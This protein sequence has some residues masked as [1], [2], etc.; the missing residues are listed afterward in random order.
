MAE[1]EE[2]VEAEMTAE[3]EPLAEAEVAD[4]E[5]QPGDDVT[6]AEQQAD[7]EEQPAN[8]QQS[9][10]DQ[11]TTEEEQTTSDEE[12]VSEQP[13]NTEQKPDAE[14]TRE[15]DA[16]A[17]PDQVPDG[18]EEE[19]GP[20]SWNLYLVKY[21]PVHVGSAPGP[22]SNGLDSDHDSAANGV[23]GEAENG[24]EP[25]LAPEVT[26]EVDGRAAAK[27]PAGAWS[28]VQRPERDEDKAPA[29]AQEAQGSKPQLEQGLNRH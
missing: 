1:T 5:Q 18:P 22:G 21:P 20:Q 2:Q 26:E 24:K 17:E 29:S 13:A 28:G 12:A 8:D 9:L 23:Q 14:H 10:G 11:Q 4:A 7:A 6:E 16:S 27:E 25:R 15:A 19:E 3:G